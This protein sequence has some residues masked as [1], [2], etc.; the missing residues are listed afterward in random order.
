ME[1]R[2]LIDSFN[3]AITGLI[4]ALRT[5]RNMRIHFILALIALFLSILFDVSK[6][7]LLILFFTISLV[8]ITEMINTAVEAVVDL[9]TRRYHPLARI[10]KNVAAGAVLF[11]AINAIIVGYLIFVDDLTP[12]T[13]YLFNRIRQSP[14]HLTFVSL[15]VTIFVVILGKSWKGKG[16]PLRGGMPSGHSAIAFSLATAI[17]LMSDNALIASLVL[18]MAFLVA[19]S[20]VESGIHSIFEVVTGGL[21]GILVTVL[22]FQFLK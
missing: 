17:A 12:V 18:L 5:Q 9:Y 8:I 21:I 6:V 20:R 14:T 15:V 10:A 13:L 1:V 22:I 7:E 2:K 16:T 4:Y 19:Q 11:A 3:Y